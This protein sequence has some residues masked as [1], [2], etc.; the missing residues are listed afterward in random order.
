MQNK[1]R[2]LSIDELKKIVPAAF[3]EAPAPTVS[4]RYG[5]IPTF[6]MIASIM[7]RGWRPF[8]ARMQRSRAAL[9]PQFATHMITFRKPGEI[10]RVGGIIPTITLINN[11]IAKMKAKIVAGFLR[12]ICSNGLMISSGI[13]DSSVVRVHLGNAEAFVAAGLEGALDK[14]GRATG[15]VESWKSLPLTPLEQMTFA[16]SA[17][18]L[19]FGDDAV[20]FATSDVLAARR[21]EDISNDLWS[22]FNVVQENLTQGGFRGP[23]RTTRAI[24]A[25]PELAR[26][27]QGLWAL[28]EQTYNGMNALRA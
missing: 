1:D 13:G 14:L 28:A 3:V 22:T 21:M 6:K 18:E 27:N 25:V 26:V 19:K 20:R 15:Q 24:Q 11:H 23:T 9:M 16:H 5:F 10:I 12:L 2:E 7:E 8:Q 4:K 17:L